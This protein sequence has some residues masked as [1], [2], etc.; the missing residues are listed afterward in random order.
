MIEL[1]ILILGIIYVLIVLTVTLGMYRLPKSTYKS[2]EELPTVAVVVSAKN[3]E[4]DLPKCIAKLEK[5]DYPKDKLQ[6]VLVNDDSDDST[7]EIIRAAADRNPHF[8]AL[9]TSNAPDNGLKAKARGIAWG[10]ENSE[11]EWIFITDADGE[12]PEL[13][14]RHSL[15]LVDDTIGMTGGMLSVNPVSTLAVLERVSWAYTLPFAF[16][17][18]GWG[19]SFIC[20]GPNMGLRRSI[21]EDCGGLE[22]SDFEI[23]EDLA[24]FRMVENSEYTSLSY[25]SPETTV[26]LNPVPSLRH[27]LSQQRRWLRGGFEGGWQYWIGLVLGFGFHNILSFFMIFGWFFS[28]EATAITVSMKLSIDF[29]QLVSTR[30]LIKEGNFIRYYPVFALYVMI[31][32]LWLPVSLLFH[33]KIKWQGEGYE[34]KYD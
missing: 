29:I 8:K 24:L 14:L 30:H 13:W 4:D 11:S 32:L 17:M 31:T 16:G 20:V 23:A 6:I 26:H 18:A 28:V 12:V 1:V 21:Y 10:I 3:E 19:S 33:S 7:G 5:L 25:M 22:N 15:S 34:I 9:D 2:D 27:L